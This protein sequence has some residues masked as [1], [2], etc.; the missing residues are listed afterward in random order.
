MMK[1]YGYWRSSASYRVRIALNLK[2][3][4]Y[5]YIPVNLREAEHRSPKYLAKNPQGLVPMLELSDGSRLTQSLAILDYLDGAFRSP[6]LLPKDSL[7]RAQIIA[8]ANIIASD[9]APIQ[10]LR[11]LQFIRGEYDQDDADVKA[12]AA[13]WIADGLSK[14]EAMLSMD[15]YKFVVNQVPGYFECVLIPKIYNGVR[16][17]VDIA[18]FPLI[19]AIN[20]KCSALPA[21]EKALP[22]NQPDS[23]KDSS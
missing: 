3:I 12:W 22:E 16:F 4:G 13:H 20:K 11:V 14:V 9:T 18:D 23:M 6:D 10:N 17:G 2:G 15:Y 21:F 1:L 19:H 5:E 7:K 8:L